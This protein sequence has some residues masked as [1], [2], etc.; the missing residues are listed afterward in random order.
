MQQQRGLIM[1]MN[2]LLLAT[3]VA[4]TSLPL[5]ANQC[6]AQSLCDKRV[7]CAREENDVDYSSDAAAVCSAEYQA[8]IAALEANEEDECHRLARATVALDTCRIGLRCEDF[9]AQDLGGECDDEDDELR[10]ALEEVDGLECTAQ[11]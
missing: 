1:P 8:Q 11:E 5:M 7:Q 9:L 10:D 4:A 3:L 2:R 6:T